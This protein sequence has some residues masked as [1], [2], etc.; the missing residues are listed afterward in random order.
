MVVCNDLPNLLPY[1]RYIF[2]TV[3]TKIPTPNSNRDFLPVAIL[4]FLS[5]AMEKVWQIKLHF[6]C[7]TKSLY[8]T[9]SHDSGR[10]VVEG[11]KQDLDEKIISFLLLL[12]HRNAFDMV[13]PINLTLKLEEM[14]Q[15]SN[16]PVNSYCRITGFARKQCS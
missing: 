9:I 15:F 12:D 16:Q 10:Y 7:M 5:K 2:N 4:R 1:I 8:E 13:V 6:T 11:S 14:F 3:P